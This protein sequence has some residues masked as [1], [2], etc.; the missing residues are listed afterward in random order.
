[1]LSCSLICPVYLHQPFFF[2]PVAQ[3]WHHLCL[4]PLTSSAIP[5]CCRAEG[6]GIVLQ[7]LPCLQQIPAKPHGVL[8][9]R[10]RWLQRSNLTA[11]V[12]PESEEGKRMSVPLWAQWEESRLPW[13]SSPA[14]LASLLPMPLEKDGCYLGQYL[15]AKR[16]P[17]FCL[18]LH[19]FTSPCCCLLDF[20]WAWK[21]CKNWWE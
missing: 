2:D 19:H 13:S 15:S 20:V 16:E 4:T 5:Y 7:G 9:M 14:W 12:L 6:T 1:M 10:L 21:R 8:R 3:L 11:T 18:S 17:F